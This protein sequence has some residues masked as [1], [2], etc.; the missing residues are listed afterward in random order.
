MLRRRELLGLAAAALTCPTGHTPQRVLVLGGTRWIGPH[1]VAAL[2]ARGHAP[3]LLNRG[4][5]AP[6]LFPDI[7][8]IRADRAGDLS[9]LTGRTWDAALDLSGTRPRWVETA[10]RRLAGAVRRY[11]LMSSTAVYARY[12]GERVD[13]S[14]PLRTLAPDRRDDPK[15]NYGARKAACEQAAEAALPGR[16]CALRA[17]FVIGPGEPELRAAAWLARFAAGGT[18][19]LPGAPAHLLLYVDVRDLADLVV[20]ALERALVGPFNVTHRA[21]LAAWTTVCRL[22][23]GTAPTIVWTGD[24]SIGAPM[25][26]VP[27]GPTLRWGDLDTTRA[28]AAGFDPRP[29]AATLGDTWRALQA[30]PDQHAAA[31]RV[32]R[33]AAVTPA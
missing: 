14:L 18:I 16:V 4:R 23:S 33:A 20:H 7:E 30:D 32:W 12:D 27:H 10:A 29:L 3:T 15:A 21:T 26:H 8:K 28:R 2:L 19:R 13:E 31:S 25:L 5:T 17:S 1:V 6:G 9:A 24:A 22:A 11:L